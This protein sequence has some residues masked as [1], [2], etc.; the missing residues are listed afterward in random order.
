MTVKECID[1][2]TVLSDTIF[3]KKRHR[4][5]ISSRQLQGRFD[6]AGLEQAIQ[7]MIVRKGLNK[8]EQLKCTVESACKVLVSETDTE[9]H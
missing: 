2:Y 4:F 3:Q 1:A 6:T 9:L 7:G 8:D 5:K